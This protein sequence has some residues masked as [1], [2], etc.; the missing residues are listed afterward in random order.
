VT[1]NGSLHLGAAGQLISYVDFTAHDGLGKLDLTHISSVVDAS[2]DLSF[3]VTA[4]DG[5][6]DTALGSIG[7]HLEGSLTLAGTPGVDVFGVGSHSGVET[8]ANFG[9]N[10]KIDL[11]GL[12]DSIYGGTQDQSSVQVLVDSSNNSNLK[13]QVADTSHVFH[14]VAVLSGY[15]TA[16]SDVVNVILNEATHQ[17]HTY[18][19]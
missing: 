18:T 8:I 19:A 7:I 9:S 2:Q 10:D 3:N 17:T 16:G 6:G 5:D 12:L 14:D 4:T 1:E 11:S 15:N 13:V